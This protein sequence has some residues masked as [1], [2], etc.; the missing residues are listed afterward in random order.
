MTW[1]RLRSAELDEARDGLADH[2]LQLAGAGLEPDLSGLE[3][4]DGEQVVGEPGQVLGLRA[5]LPDA[6]IACAGGEP[7]A[8]VLHQAHPRL[9]LGQRRAQ[10]VRGQHHEVALDAVDLAQL[11]EGHRLQLV[12][13]GELPGPVLDHLARQ[14]AADQGDDDEEEEPFGEEVGV[15]GV[16]GLVV[17]EADP[18]VDGR[19]AHRAEEAAAQP[20]AQAAGDD[21]K[22]KTRPS[23]E[24]NPPVR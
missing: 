19:D 8:R 6:L 3:L 24:L 5:Q 20:E 11:V 13:V 17:E 10:L 9:D 2:R 22:V 21:H 18:Q 16:E 23:W 15:G 1:K 7:I 14:Q 12:G 4:G